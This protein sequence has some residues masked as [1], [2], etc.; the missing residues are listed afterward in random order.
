MRKEFKT[1]LL[2][3][4]ANFNYEDAL[5]LSDEI[6]EYEANEHAITDAEDRL[7]LRLTVQIEKT[8]RAQRDQARIV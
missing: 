6:H 2:G 8:R 4:L 7:W 1:R 5:K 3:A